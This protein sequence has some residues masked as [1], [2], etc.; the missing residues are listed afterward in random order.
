MLWVLTQDQK[1]LINA[2]EVTANGKK[3]EGVIGSG[4]LDSYVLGK[5][6]SNDRALE[7]L[8]EILTKMEENTGVSVTF[9][10]PEK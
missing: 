5:Y 4:L 7:I 9:S 10:M 2:R 8:K 3:V 1:R 6:E